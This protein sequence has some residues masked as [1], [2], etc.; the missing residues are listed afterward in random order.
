MVVLVVCGLYGAMAASLV[1]LSP[2][3]LMVEDRL[4]ALSLFP[5]GFSLVAKRN[6]FFSRIGIRPRKSWGIYLLLF[7]SLNALK[8]FHIF[9]FR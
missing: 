6:I 7:A 2:Q 9:G 8:V 5:M 3:E 4:V 1:F